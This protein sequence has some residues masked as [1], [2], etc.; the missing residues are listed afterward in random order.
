MERDLQYWSSQLIYSEGYF[1]PILS[2]QP[3]ATE[4]ISLLLS[5]ELVCEA[6]LS[7]P[8]AVPAGRSW[9]LALDASSTGKP[10]LC[11]QCVEFSLSSFR[12]LPIQCHCLTMFLWTNCFHPQFLCTSHPHTLCGMW[13]CRARSDS[14]SEL[15]TPPN[16]QNCPSPP[17]VLMSVFLR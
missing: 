10:W 4:H 15:K 11:Q 12:S 14:K 9:L 3:F 5:V 7:L 17:T 2:P 1:A 16:T 13:V 8:L 6:R